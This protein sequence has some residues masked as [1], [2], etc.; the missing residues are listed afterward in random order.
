MAYPPRIHL[1][2]V[3][4]DKHTPKTL[5]GTS[6]P[7]PSFRPGEAAIPFRTDLT[8]TSAARIMATLGFCSGGVLVGAW[9]FWAFYR[10]LAGT[11]E[12]AP[13]IKHVLLQLNLGAENVVA[14]WYSSML[15]FLVAIASTACF[16]AD[17]RGAGARRDRVLSY[18]WLGLAGVFTLLSLDEMGSVHERLSMLSALNPF[19]DAP[20]GWVFLLAPFIVAVSALMVGFGW[21]HLRRR[22]GAFTLMVVGVAAFLSVPVQEYI[23]V[24]VMRAAAGEGWERPT[25]L[26]LLEEGSEFLGTLSVLAATL[27]YW[28]AAGASATRVSTRQAV[29]GLACVALLLGLGGAAVSATLGGLDGDDGNPSN[30]PPAV[31]AFLV[32]VLCGNLARAAP[33]RSSTR[34]AYLGLGLFSL[35]ASAYVG[36]GIYYFADWR[37]IGPRVMAAALAL[38]LL[39]SS[40]YAVALRRPLY[41]PV[42]VTSVVALVLSLAHSGYFVLP[43]A[44]FVSALGLGVGVLL[45]TDAETAEVLPSHRVGVREVPLQPVR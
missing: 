4:F 3:P 45:R 16:V 5:G 35:L 34:R 24:D 29:V 26:L 41:I 25:S 15:L 43:T 14:A 33:P 8:P 32:A 2:C 31:L 22:P 27:L 17:R 10:G 38:A 19:E 39:A 30:W 9:A 40:V 37:P 1:P 18:G 7:L 36:G 44:L 11:W 23:E 28:S 12:S 20:L 21:L 6:Y 42:T 13:P